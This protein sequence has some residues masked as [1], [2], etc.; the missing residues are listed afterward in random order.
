[1][2][3]ARKRVIEGEI[4]EIHL[5]F[6]KKVKI[7]LINCFIRCNNVFK[8]LPNILQKFEIKLSQV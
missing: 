1:M 6:A 8:Y 2:K 7:P 3:I 4:Y 5:F